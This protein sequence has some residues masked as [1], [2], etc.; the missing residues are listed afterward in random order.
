MR[1]HSGVAARLFEA[2]GKGGVNIQMISTSEIKIAVIIDEARSS[3][4][5]TLLMKHL[6]W[7]GRPVHS[8]GQNP[9][10][11]GWQSRP[12][13]HLSKGVYHGLALV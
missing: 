3:K 4:P 7:P 6:T 9:C 2:L 11:G 5:R 13:H 8:L 1:S 12:I 10:K